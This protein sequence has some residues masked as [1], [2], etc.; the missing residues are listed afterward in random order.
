MMIECLSF[1]LD[2]FFNMSLFLVVDFYFFDAVVCSKVALE[3]VSEEIDEFFHL[4][5][6]VLQIP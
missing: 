1:I 4:F 3:V 2:H 5:S 6:I